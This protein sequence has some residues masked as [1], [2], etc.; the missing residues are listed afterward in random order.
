MFQSVTILGHVGRDPELKTTTTG[1][2]VCK[3]SVATSYSYG[4]NKET[5]WWDVTVWEKRAE[6]CAKYLVKGSKV[7]VVGRIKTRTYEDK[8][9]IKRWARD[10][11]ASEVKFLSSNEGSAPT[12]QDAQG[13]DKE[14]DLEF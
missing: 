13:D 3:F 7:L 14:D 5:E 6:S 10:L 1:K 8:D 12:R 2:T 9:G 11:I 4:E